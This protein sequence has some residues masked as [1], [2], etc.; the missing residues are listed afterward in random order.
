MADKAEAER[1]ELTLEDRA[2]AYAELVKEYGEARAK[3]LLEA[4]K[5]DVAAIEKRA[6]EIAVALEAATVK[7]EEPKEIGAAIVSELAKAERVE[8]V[9]K[10]ERRWKQL[11]NGSWEYSVNGGMWRRWF[12]PPPKEVLGPKPEPQPPKPEEEEE[13]KAANEPEGKLPAIIKPPPA[14]ADWDQ[15]LA[16]M[17]RQHA[18]IENVGGKAVIASWEPSSHDPGGRLM[19]V[20][21]NKESFLLRYSNRSVPIE[22]QTGRGVST[23]VRMPLGQW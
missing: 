19:V 12:G 13:K 14:P 21:Q 23:I 7:R 11:S 4:A 2:I 15:A 17:N 10:V 9:V 16:A 18:I 8:E 3:E 6:A 1:R 22:V 20:F 5:V